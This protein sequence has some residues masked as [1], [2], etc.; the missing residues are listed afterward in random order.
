MISLHVSELVFPIIFTSTRML[1][2]ISRTNIPSKPWKTKTVC[3]RSK[4]AHRLVSTVGA[5][6]Q[7]TLMFFFLIT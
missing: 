2:I 7:G 5:W 1:T 6:K 4:T 3:S